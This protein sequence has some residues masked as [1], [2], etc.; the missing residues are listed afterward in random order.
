[1]KLFT[2]EVLKSFEKVGSQ[3][4]TPNPEIICKIFNPCGSQ[5]GYLTEYSPAEDSFFGYVTGMFE[6]EWGYISRKELEDFRS[7]P[8]GLPLERDLCFKGKKFQ[9]VIKSN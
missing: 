7:R 6:D 8:F 5:R 3:E 4:Y 1:M 9:D 2:K